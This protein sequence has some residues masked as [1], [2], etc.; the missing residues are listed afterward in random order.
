VSDEAAAVFHRFGGGRAITIAS[1]LGEHYHAFAFGEH[2]Q[3]IAN[4]VRVLAAPPVTV[5]NAG[6]F[7]EVSLRRAAGGETVLHLLNHAG[8]ER[9]YERILPLRG[10]HVTLRTTE[11]VASARATR[12]GRDLAFEQAGDV[13]RFTVD[14]DGEYEMIAIS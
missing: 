14:L 13:L 7:V 9:P 2:R 1:D 6:E 10:L 8:V 5:E 3:M 4:V 11:Q 12:A